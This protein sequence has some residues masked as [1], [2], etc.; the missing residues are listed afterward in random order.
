M[1]RRQRGDAVIFL[2]T[3]VGVAALVALVWALV[4]EA[5]EWESFKQQHHCKVVAKISGSTFNTIGSD[6]KI[7]VGT[8]PSKTGW[9]CDDGVTYYR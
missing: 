6:G 2:I 1:I 5:R 8:T 4:V 3:V 7:G 9:A